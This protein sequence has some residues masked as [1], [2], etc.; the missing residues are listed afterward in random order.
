M[1]R[2]YLEMFE[3][4]DIRTLFYAQNFARLMGA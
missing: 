2:S 4:A 1:H 3:N